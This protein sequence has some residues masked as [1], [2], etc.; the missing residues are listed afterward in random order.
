MDIETTRQLEILGELY[1]VHLV[2]NNLLSVGSRPKSRNKSCKDCQEQSG[3]AYISDEPI[4]GGA[5]DY[6]ESL[7]SPFP[8]IKSAEED[9]E[10]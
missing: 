3:D 2:L 6:V 1:S 9:N 10:D 7:I 4:V 5:A 8:A